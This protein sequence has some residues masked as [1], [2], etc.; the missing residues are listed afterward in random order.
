MYRP[1]T[2]Q[3]PFLILALLVLLALLAACNAAVPTPAAP[4]GADNSATDSDASDTAAVAGIAAEIVPVAQTSSP[5]VLPAPLYYLNAQGQIMRLERDGV[6]STT[7]TPNDAG[8]ADYDVSP[9]GRML[10][11]VSGNDLILFDVTSSARTVRLAG[12]TFP[13]DDYASMFTKSITSPRFSPDGSQIVFGMGGINVA[14]IAPGDPLTLVQPSDPY[15]DFDAEPKPPLA[16]PVRFFT[17]AEWSP[18]GQSLL[19]SFGYFPE[20]GGIAIKDLLT[21]KLLEVEDNGIHCCDLAWTGEATALIGSAIWIYGMPGL[22]QI[23]ARTGAGQTLLAGYPAGEPGPE[24]AMRLVRAP[25]QA[26]GE[27]AYVFVSAGNSYDLDTSV[28][29]YS[30]AQLNSDGSL[31]QVSDTPYQLPGDITWAPDGS[32]VV[33]VNPADP[34]MRAVN[35]SFPLNNTMSWLPINGQETLLLPIKGHQPRWGGPAQPVDGPDGAALAELKAKA[36]ADFGLQA[37]D[38]GI[39]V[40]Q[41]TSDG[42]RL[43]WAVFSTGMR[44]FDPLANHQVAIYTYDNGWLELARRELS[45]DDPAANGVSPDILGGGSLNQVLVEPTHIWLTVQG[46]VGAHGGAFL[47]LNFDGTSLNI[48]TGNFNGSPDAGHVSDINGDGRAEVLLNLT[49]PYI[50]A[51][52]SGVRLVQY[53]I[54]RWDGSQLIPVQLAPLS[55]SAPAAAR[56]A[57]NQAILFANAGLW[58]DAQTAAQV[59]VSAAP[60]DQTAIWNAHFVNYNSDAKRMAHGGFGDPYPL[61]TYVF[62]GNYETAVSVMRGFSAAQLFSASSPLVVGTAAEGWQEQLGQT[63]VM[64]AGSALA[65]RPDL[66]PAYFLRAWG[67]YLLNPADPAI[68][69][70]LQKAVELAP[71]DSLYAEALTLFP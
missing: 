5:A 34:V 29:W 2:L 58:Q 44:T 63:L 36:A 41:L 45:S 25:F 60:D 12:E 6:T 48:V 16:G 52:A 31:T 57:T 30:L 46:V 50:F 14:G 13:A 18:D 68:K 70:D 66:A 47:A 64:N 62:A 23:D 51:Y 65:A 33:F 71:A 19:L 59:A 37:A 67:S 61:L 69:T 40:R 38:Q 56:D 28:A 8:I 27:P 42:Q 7:V 39:S 4:A 43:L 49:E 15:P 55:D 24:T 20:G 10:V 22:A 26:N 1:I 21:N 11:Y 3:R 53:A 35:P 17:K 54:L 9:D 32:G